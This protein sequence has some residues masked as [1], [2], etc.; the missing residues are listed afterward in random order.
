[1]AKPE[2]VRMVTGVSDEKAWE[3]I[4]SA[5]QVVEQ[6]NQEYGFISKAE[7][8]IKEEESVKEDNG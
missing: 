7:E 5:R 4:T 8:T 1:M 6:I 3:F 2:F